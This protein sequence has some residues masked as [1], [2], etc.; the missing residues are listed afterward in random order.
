MTEILNDCPDSRSDITPRLCFMG[1]GI[2][3]HKRYTWKLLVVFCHWSLSFFPS[4]I[5]PLS[6]LVI[7]GTA[8]VVSIFSGSAGSFPTP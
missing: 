1:Y 8:L 3:I 2:K 6:F 7:L 4:L 5:L